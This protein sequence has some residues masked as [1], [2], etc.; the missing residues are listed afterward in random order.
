MTEADNMRR[1]ADGLAEFLRSLPDDDA[2]MAGWRAVTALRDG[3]ATVE[4][5]RA[6]LDAWAAQA[7]RRVGRAIGGTVGSFTDG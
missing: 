6:S 2:S 7:V 1:A 4:G 3:A 5:Q